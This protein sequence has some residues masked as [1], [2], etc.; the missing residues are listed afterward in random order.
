MNV[1]ER[2]DEPILACLTVATMRKCNRNVALGAEIL[3]VRTSVLAPLDAVRLF[4]ANSLQ[5]IKRCSV[6]KR[7]Q[8]AG[9]GHQETDLH[10]GE[11]SLDCLRG[12]SRAI[13]GKI[14]LVSPRV[15]MYETVDGGNDLIQN[16]DFDRRN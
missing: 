5:A 8:M 13:L 3:S 14:S 15:D 6:L 9:W 12:P 16:Q 2:S 10:K 4:Y 1:I 11:L 7:H